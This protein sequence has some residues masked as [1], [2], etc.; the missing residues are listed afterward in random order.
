MELLILI[1]KC[2]LIGLIWAALLIPIISN[3]GGAL[4]Y[5]ITV[6]VVTVLCFIFRGYAYIINQMTLIALISLVLSWIISMAVFDK[7]SKVK[8]KIISFTCVISG[9]AYLTST[10]LATN[11]HI[12]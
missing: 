6:A 4:T 5:A 11:I 1:G 10:L 2:I 3:R 7:E 12:L 9:L 8:S